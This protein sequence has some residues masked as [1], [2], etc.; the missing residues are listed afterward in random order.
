MTEFLILSLGSVTLMTV[1]ALCALMRGIAGLIAQR[2]AQIHWEHVLLIALTLLTA[3]QYLMSYGE[4]TLRVVNGLLAQNAELL[5]MIE[6]R[7]LGLFGLLAG[8]SMNVIMALLF[9]KNG[10]YKT[11]FDTVFRRLTLVITFTLFCTAI[12]SIALINAEKAIFIHADGMLMFTIVSK[13]AFT[14]L[15]A[16]LAIYEYTTNTGPMPNRLPRQIVITLGTLG[17]VFLWYRLLFTDLL[18]IAA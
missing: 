14:A 17:G 1:I 9:A 16:A 3:L 6:L 15:F 5:G 11:H 4:V 7:W 8:L 18:P 2:Q 10:D 12:V 13:L